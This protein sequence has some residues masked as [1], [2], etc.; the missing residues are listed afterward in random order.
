MSII[1]NLVQYYLNAVIFLS[2]T[3]YILMLYID[4]EKLSKNSKLFISDITEYSQFAI[5]ISVFEYVKVFL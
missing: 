4:I 3:V 2:L 1:T 5:F